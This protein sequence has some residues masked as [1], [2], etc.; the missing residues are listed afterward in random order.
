MMMLVVV[1]VVV[2]MLMTIYNMMQ[3]VFVCHEKSSLPTSELSAR[4][5]K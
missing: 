3:H 5:A 1:V 2:V 4:G